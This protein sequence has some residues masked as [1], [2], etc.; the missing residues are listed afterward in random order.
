MIYT[1]VEIKTSQCGTKKAIL[2]VSFGTTHKDTMKKTIEKI[3]DRI[4]EK[5]KGYEVRRAF[6]AHIIIK[7]LKERDGIIE[8][9][10]EEALEKL[11]IEGYEEVIVQPLHIIP[12]EEY[13]Y[14]KNVVENFTKKGIFKKIV[15][16]RSALYFKGEEEFP[17]D[18]TIFVDSIREILEKK[19]TI[20]MMGH[21]SSH[22][23]NAC[24]PCLQ[25]VLLDHGYEHVY[26]GTVEGYPT[27][28]KVIDRLKKAS[29]KDV[30][31]VPLMLVAGDHVKNDMAGEDEDSWKSLL[32]KEGINTNLFMHGLGEFEKF[33]NIYLQHISDAIKETYARIGQTKKGKML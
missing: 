32:N 30:T 33:Q 11:R 17:D 22:P 23:A 2:A 16:G 31:L 25:S 14:I 20:V 13:H 26:V 8:D 29:V 12:G 7:V 28:S 10:P 24:Y 27:I 5:F 3:E 4:R 21:G 1:P 9:T 15:L 6:T 18:Y 19:G